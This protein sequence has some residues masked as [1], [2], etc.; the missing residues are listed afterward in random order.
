MSHISAKMMNLMTQTQKQTSNDQ[1]MTKLRY[2]WQ[3]I[4]KSDSVSD[5]VDDH[6][7]DRLLKRNADLQVSASVLKSFH[8]EE[9][10]SSWD[11]MVFF[12]GRDEDLQECWSLNFVALMESCIEETVS[13]PAR[14]RGLDDADPD[15]PDRDDEQ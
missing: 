15:L 7:A 6:T 4:E 2:G 1:T 12:F 8:T 13:N 11:P 5:D 3:R 14:A 9:W 10:R